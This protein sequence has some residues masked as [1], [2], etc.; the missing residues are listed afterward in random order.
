[1]EKG[2]ALE[3]AET[4]KR[5]YL[6]P[7]NRRTLGGLFGNDIA[8]CIGQ[9]VT[10]EGV[11]MR[12][13]GRNT[14]PVRLGPATDKPTPRQVDTTTGEIMPATTAIDEPDPITEMLNEEASA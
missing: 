4:D 11:P 2:P 5:L 7:T 1:V 6:S 10:L 14:C 9:H 8:A 12:V 13:A 3:F